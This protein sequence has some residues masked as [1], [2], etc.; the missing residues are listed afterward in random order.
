MGGMETELLFSVHIEKTK[1]VVAQIGVQLVL[2]F[3][4]LLNAAR[5]FLVVGK[6]KI[7]AEKVAQKAQLAG[8]IGTHTTAGVQGGLGKTAGDFGDFLVANLGK[9][10][11]DEHCGGVVRG[12]VAI[13]EG[14]AVKVYSTLLKGG[15]K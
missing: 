14:N 4:V 15:V 10:G 12:D 2:I 9:M 13:D 8:I 6:A 3:A 5:K 11:V 7:V 1:V